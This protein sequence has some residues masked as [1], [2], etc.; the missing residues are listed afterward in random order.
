MYT[1]EGFVAVEVLPSPKSQLYP[2]MSPLLS[3]V[4]FTDSGASPEDGEREKAAT[5]AGGGGGGG[6][7][8][9]VMHEEHTAVS[10]PPGPVA[11]KVT[12]Y[13]PALV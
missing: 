7:S 8:S 1:W 11:V 9:T 12:L 3:L 2:L 6:G 5:G 13:T 4:K 10:E